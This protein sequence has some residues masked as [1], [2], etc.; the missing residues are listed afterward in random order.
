MSSSLKWLVRAVLST[1][2]AL[3]LPVG[4]SDSSP[5]TPPLSP[6]GFT[7][8]LSTNSATLT[9]CTAHSVLLCYGITYAQVLITVQRDR[10]PGDIT[11]YLVP[12][13]SAVAVDLGPS[14]LSNTP[15][16]PSATPNQGGLSL[17]V[18]TFGAPYPASGYG[19]Q[20]FLIRA[21]GPDGLVRTAPF[22]LTVSR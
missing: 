7:M 5:V 18:F 19:V 13:P 8:S 2:A 4:C 16:G 21:Q 10:Y 22:T 15:V 3:V 20:Q 11:L 12:P 17:S 1:A 9:P 14:V 6:P